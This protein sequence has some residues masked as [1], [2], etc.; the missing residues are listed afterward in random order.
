MADTTFSAARIP[1]VCGFNLLEMFSYSAE[2]PH[3]QP[4][5]EW[6]FDFMA[7]HGFRFARLPLDYRFWTRD[8]DGPRRQIDEAILD[9]LAQAVRLGQARGI[10]VCVNIH[11]APGYCINRPELEPFNLW[12]DPP[13]V[14]AFAFHW[15]AIAE[16]L[17][18]FSS[19]ACSLD[20]LNEPPNYGDRGFAPES[21]RRVMAAAVAAIRQVSPDRLVICDGANVGTKP[22]FEL[23]DLGVAQST[24]GYA[25]W[26]LTHY[27]A[28]WVNKPADYDWPQPQWPVRYRDVR[29]GPPYD[30]E[31][32][33]DLYRPWRELVGHGI[34]V[35]CGE[36]GI[37]STV[38]ADVAHAFIDDLLTVLGECGWGWALWNLRGSFGIL[39]NDRPGVNWEACDGHRLD[40]GLL[41]ILKSH[42]I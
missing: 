38:P 9:R 28:A 24:R 23:A 31:G 4:F 34:G 33:R 16:R 17:K 41:E 10:H 8:L 20:L 37:F 42:V 1:P 14:E 25:P 3:G 32:L 27:K 29:F 2:N 11:R 40:R 6:D 19:Q 15:R 39:D 5:Q 26:Q 13:A 22:A 7:R 30:I 18:E 35:H 21:H 36:Y 12:T